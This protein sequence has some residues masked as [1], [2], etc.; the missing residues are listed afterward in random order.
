MSCKKINTTEMIFNWISCELKRKQKKNN[1]LNWIN[2]NESIN[3]CIIKSIC[4]LCLLRTFKWPFNK[5]IIN[6][7]RWV[8]IILL[9]LHIFLQF[10]CWF[11]LWQ[12]WIDIFYRYGIQKDIQNGMQTLIKC[13][14]LCLW[15]KSNK[16]KNSDT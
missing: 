1:K 7:W 11:N 4:F 10:L 16:L 2:Q 13:C 15:A 8:Q 12:W 9:L 5:S 14:S 3:L 6:I